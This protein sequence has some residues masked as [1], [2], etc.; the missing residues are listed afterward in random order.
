MLRPCLLVAVTLLAG[1]CSA[2]NSQ[3]QPG[4]ASS[5]PSGLGS[6]PT[7]PGST[8]TSPGRTPTSP[9]ESG[10]RLLNAGARLPILRSFGVQADRWRTCRHLSRP[11]RRPS[12]ATRS[13]CSSSA[14]AIRSP[15]VSTRPRASLAGDWHA[16]TRPAG[17]RRARVGA[18]SARPGV[19]RSREPKRA[20][21]RGRIVRQWPKRSANCARGRRRQRGHR[22]S[23]ARQTLRAHA[24]CRFVHAFTRSFSSR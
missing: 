21:K 12:S 17:P 16:P 6:I 8:R 14:R 9:G 15:R 20:A 24:R 2:D 23:R 22:R 3:P 10:N 4:T 1:A 19:T 18:T 13:W 7:S 5:T 11:R